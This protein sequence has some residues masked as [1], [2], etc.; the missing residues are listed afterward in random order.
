MSYVYIG[1]ECHLSEGGAMSVICVQEPRVQCKK[2]PVNVICLQ[3]PKC[4]LH[5]GGILSVMCRD[6]MILCEE[7][8]VTFVYNVM[9]VPKVREEL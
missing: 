8:R 7:L 9:S 2:G 3:R 5:E 6:L 4:P 1:P